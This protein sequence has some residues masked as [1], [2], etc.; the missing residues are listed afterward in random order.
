MNGRKD[1][2]VFALG[3]V[4]LVL[5][6]FALAELPALI[7][8]KV[9]F[10]NAEKLSPTLSPDG[11]MLAY[12]APDKQGVMNVWVRT[13]GQTDDHVVTSEKR[14]VFNYE[15][16]QDSQYILYT[17]DNNGDENFHV[18]QTDLKGTNT[19]DLTPYAGVQVRT[20]AAHVT[21]PDFPDQILVALNIRDRRLHDV[22]RVNLHS[23]AM[24]LDTE[25]PGD[26]AS[27]NADNRFQVRV[28]QVFLP[29]GGT[30]IRLRDNR[31]AAWRSFQKWG[32]DETFG[33]VV[34]FSPDNE[35][36]WMIS[37]VDANSARLLEIDIQTG[38]SKVVAEDKQ[39]D[40]TGILT[41]PRKRNLEAVQFQRA[42][43]EWL[44]TAASVE[45]DFDALKKVHDGDVNIENRSLDDKAWIVS[46]TV[47]DGP[48][49]YYL[50]DQP[51]KKST[52]LFTHRPKLE[53]YQL[54]KMQPISYKARDGMT[55][56]GYLTLPTGVEP[57][58]LPMILNVHGGPWGRDVWGWNREVQWLANRGYAVLQINFR[59][60]TGY[61][62]DYLNAGNREWAGKMHNDLL[63]GKAWAVQQ[64]YADPK[65]VCIYGGSYGGYATLV[66]VSFTPNEFVCGVDLFGPS[67]LLTLM[68]SIPPYWVPIKSMFN[69]R[70]GN[71]ETE[72][73]FLKSK[74]PLFKADQISVPLLIAQGANDARV[75]E[76]ESNQIVAAVRKNG[77]EVEYLI[78]PDEGHGFVRPANNLKF[79]AAA[80]PFLAKYLGGR[81]EPPSD[82]EKSDDLRH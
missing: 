36:V 26:V 28:A 35:R 22:Y 27:W 12:L 54:S 59:G 33:G 75:K 77:K 61:G 58:N 70:M 7:P 76:A 17:Q 62:K 41:H 42:R 69:R 34:G 52:L 5:T 50:Y 20:V 14:D 46:Y 4:W 47:A 49:Y 82:E 9:L 11:K 56:Y 29:D 21:D 6:T 25:N 18:Y 10:G 48:I 45:E 23:G 79:Y 72:P 1:S 43:S 19:R 3:L 30:E 64:G 74:S 60:S 8:R 80:E 73:E 57:K 66:G 55:I 13:L 53:Q 31:S 16:Q 67:N 68:Q 32:P 81:F 44:V 71:A 39:F 15:W 78:F 2:L 63:D 51:T 38:K 37:S 65:R 40:V 24:D